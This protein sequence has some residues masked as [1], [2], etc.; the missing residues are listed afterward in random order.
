MGPGSF[1]VCRLRQSI[2]GLIL[3]YVGIC[4]ADVLVYVCMYMYMDVNTFMR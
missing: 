4:F 1:I 3:V 2:F